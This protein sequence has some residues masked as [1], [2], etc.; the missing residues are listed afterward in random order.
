MMRDVYLHGAVGRRFGRHWRLDVETPG[1]AVRAIMT[2]RPQVRS[3]LREGWWRVIVGPPHIANTIALHLIGMRAGRQP[4]H[5]VPATPPAGGD[6]TLGKIAVGVVLIGASIATAGIAS[7]GFAA[8]FGAAMSTEIGLGIT[9]NTIALAGGAMVL[10]GIAGLLVAQPQ[11]AT[12]QQA[13]DQA[14]PD[15]RPSFFFNG[16][17]NNS[18]QGGP[19]PL[20]FGTHLVGS[21]VA[22]GG[23]NV[24]DIAV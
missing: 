5:I 9:F 4:I 20:V 7:A 6:S 16:V 8:G 10:G 13:T 15:D 19:V 24:E 11:G 1:E 17:T 2:L 22:S 12:Q 18:Q 14:R 23:I 21:I 3:A